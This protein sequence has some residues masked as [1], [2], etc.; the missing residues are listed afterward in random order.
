MIYILLKSYP[1]EGD[2]VLEVFKNPRD[3]E[4][5]KDAAIL[6][7]DSNGYNNF[8]VEPWEVT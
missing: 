2:V 1:H 8:Y 4:K 6:A 5:A 3:A 7:D